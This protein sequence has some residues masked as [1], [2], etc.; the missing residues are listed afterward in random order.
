[1]KKNIFFKSVL[2]QPIRA[3]ILTIL[4]G[5]AA[6]AFVARAMEFIIV[7]DE[8]NR[9]EAFYSAVGIL[10]PLRFN[11]FTTDHDVTRALDIIEGNRHVAIS[12]TRRF[13]QGVFADILN[14]AVH[15]AGR[16]DHYFN[17]VLHGVDIKMSDHFYIGRLRTPP[18]L[19]RLSDPPVMAFTVDI[20]ELIQGDPWVVRIGDRVF[21]NERGQTITLYGWMDMLLYLTESERDLIEQ[22]LWHPFGDMQVGDYALFR[23]TPS[24]WVE[25]YWLTWNIRPLVGEDGLQ[26]TWVEGEFGS[27]LFIPMPG[28]SGRSQ[29]D[30][31]V[32]Y[33]QNEDII[34]MLEYLNDE[35]T[36]ISENLS[37][38]TVIDTKDMSN[39]PR[40]MDS[41]A[42]R[43][44]DTA[45]F[46]AGRWLTHEDYLLSN[47][48]TV[49]PASIAARRGINIG[50]IITITLRDNP[51]PNWIDTPTDSIWARGVENWW[52]NN[53]SGWWG[54]TDAAHENWQSFPTYEFNL[55]VVGIYWSFPPSFHNFVSTEIFI[56]AGLM[57]EGFGWDDVPQLTGM[58]SFVLNSP[59]SEEAFLRETRTALFEQ[60]FV[61]TFVPSGF[62]V[63]AAATDPIRLSI[64]VNL[65]VFG[66]ASVLILAFAVLLYLRQW[67]KSVAIA[68]AL[69]LPKRKV[70]AQLFSP[71]VIFWVPSMIIGGLTAWFFAISQAQ[72]T[73]AVFEVYGAAVMPGIYLLMGLC[74]LLIVLVLTVVWLGGYGVV[75]RPVLV[76][77]QGGTQ[78]RR[79]FDYID[80]GVVP[81]DF[82][83]GDLEIAPLPAARFGAVLRAG[84]RHS[85]RHIFRTP[86]KT[87]LALLLALIF[88]FS[89]GW[90]N[91]TIYSTEDEIAR[92]WETTIVEAEI[93]R[94]LD[95]DERTDLW[96]SAFI[97]PDAWNAVAFSGFVGDA[98]LEALQTTEAGVFFGVSHLEGLVAENTKNPTD[99]QLGVICDDMEIE[100]LPGFGFD[101]FVYTSNGLIP[102]I[103]QRWNDDPVYKIGDRYTQ[104]I[105]VFDGGLDR[106]INQFWS[107]VLVIPLE[108]HRAIFAGEWPFYGFSSLET[109]YPTFLTA[110]FTID[111][112][113]NREIDQFR[114]LMEPMLNNNLLGNLR[115][116][117]LLLH[118]ND[119]V[120]HNVIL[121]MEQSLSLL[122]VLY[123]IAIGVAFILAIGLSLLNMLQ[124][125]K[126]AAIMRVLG[127]PRLTSQ[128]LLWTEQLLVCA[129]GVLIGLLMLFVTG[130]VVGIAS[131]YLAAVYFGGAVIGTCIGAFVVS[132]RAPLDLLQVRE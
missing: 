3:F 87:V 80:S 10:S 76:Q 70:L 118:I 5:A 89:L 75:H 77:L 22:G 102:M 124:N 48:V 29:P 26:Y 91:N 35:L 85:T 60:G 97:S 47:H 100:F 62:D 17:P 33:A 36:L 81:E 63:L 109:Y 68:Q 101:D 1:M 95:S 105:G 57:P 54:M 21:T 67:R 99:E 74:G 53:A 93:F 66:A 111:P 28:I 34:S 132:M 15:R 24:F 86:I 6:F 106:A 50:D 16:W 72:E 110:R 120:I 32:F 92:L 129:T 112:A 11:D 116:V 71:V 96:W 14:T 94:R 119:D 115:F 43:L 103:I 114:E 61:A 130:T 13:T 56:P 83:V 69:G 79:K 25:N 113:R 58:Y 73:L 18:R 37:S 2:R 8:L 51:R 42:A 125:A 126:N 131:L 12:D 90:L 59:R 45:A 39:M 65:A 41:R 55:E 128:A 104:V 64:T 122:R 9:L 27:N 107:P 117:P 98:Y 19:I 108:N 52:D 78:K 4:I 31:L 44:L 30:E 40:F 82:V 49:I 121:P 7:R 123:P 23:M 46:P 20:Y 127:K 38:V 88:V 84:L